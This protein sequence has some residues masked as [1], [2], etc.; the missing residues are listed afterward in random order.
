MNN[1]K[2][3]MIDDV[4]D[5]VIL[6]SSPKST[7]E[8]LVLREE[9]V[10]H[11]QKQKKTTRTT[12]TNPNTL[13]LYEFID[14]LPFVIHDTI[15]RYG[16]VKPENDDDDAGTLLHDPISELFN[17]LSINTTTNVEEQQ[18]DLSKFAHFDPSKNYTRNLISTDGKL[19]TLLLLCW[20][21]G[22]ESPIHDHPCDGCWMK[23]CQGSV[24]ERRYK[25]KKKTG[26]K[27]SDDDDDDGM[28][29]CVF[30]TVYNDSELAYIRDS[31]GYHKVGN[32]S[33]TKRSIT[34]HL[35]CPPFDK[36]RIWFNEG[37]TSSSMCSSSSVCCYHSQYGTLVNN[38][39]N[40][41]SSSKTKTTT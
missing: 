26:D 21:P 19:Y 38:N 29:E 12:S 15:E 40:N 24:R 31:M 14:E 37:D 36:C 34:L 13:G 35:Y 6:C 9:E 3:K 25:K 8:L 27:D 5:D 4:N 7:S 39:N 10:H 33:L 16:S 18:G 32:P 11:Y 28:L 30:D 23:T 2:K 1:N 22:K 41:S 17:R 20:N